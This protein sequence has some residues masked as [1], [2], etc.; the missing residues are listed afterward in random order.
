MQLF[1][2]FFCFF[3][4]IQILIE[5]TLSLVLTLLGIK[6]QKERKPNAGSSNLMLK[7]WM[8]LPRDLSGNI[9]HGR[10]AVAQPCTAITVGTTL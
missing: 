8:D 10:S 7:C 6:L 3:F 1:F 9:L 2:L 5:F 4:L